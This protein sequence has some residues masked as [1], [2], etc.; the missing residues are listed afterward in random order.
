MTKYFIHFF[1]VFII[2]GVLLSFS[3]CGYKGSPVYVDDKIVMLNY[4]TINV[5]TIKL[6]GSKPST[7]GQSNEPY[8]HE[9]QAQTNQTNTDFVDNNESE[10]LPF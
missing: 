5:Q 6:C 7:A 2:A 10:D 9:P 8:K 1:H 4:S 3:A